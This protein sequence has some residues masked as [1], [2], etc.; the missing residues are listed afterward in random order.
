[1][2][3]LPI[4]QMEQEAPHLSFDTLH[5]AQMALMCEIQKTGIQ[6]KRLLIAD[7][8]LPSNQPRVWVFTLDGQKPRLVMKEWVAHGAGS[9]PGKTGVPV[10]FSNRINSNETSLG[11]YEIASPYI[12]GHGW[13]YNLEGLTPGYNTNVAKRHVVLHPADYVSRGHAGRSL[14]CPA[15]RPQA[16]QALRKLGM[17]D[18]FMWIDGPGAP[19]VSCGQG[20]QA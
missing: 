2:T 20:G 15:M 17:E 18:A 12:G 10:Q 11:L 3:S 9:D 1:M 16:V 13:S 7:M 4:H 19:T 5:R 6:P 8:S 14:G